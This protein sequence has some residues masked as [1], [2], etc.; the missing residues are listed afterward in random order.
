L[1][2]LDLLAHWV[3]KVCLV[4]RVQPVR[5]VHLDQQ[6]QLDRRVSRAA[7]VSRDQRATVGRV[8]LPVHQDPMDSQGRLVTQD[9]PVVRVTV[10]RPGL[11]VPLDSQDLRGQLAKWVLLG[12]Q[13]TPATQE[14][15]GH[16]V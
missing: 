4:E 16:V 3:L 13:A 9:R 1:D 15:P 2:L 14:M 8:A 11:R 7:R 10:D 5:Q 6:V 12:H